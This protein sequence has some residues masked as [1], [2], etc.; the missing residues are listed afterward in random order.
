LAESGAEG[1]GYSSIAKALKR[2]QD[3]IGEWHDWLC[4]REEAKDALGQDAPDLS[5]FLELE[6]ERHL[7]TA[8]KTTHT[9]RARL[10]GEWMA[11][12]QLQAKRP[13]APVKITDRLGSLGTA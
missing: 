2:V 3:A 12:H 9:M 11:M 5:A 10:S 13:P 8:M 1:D 4:L 6:V 7:A